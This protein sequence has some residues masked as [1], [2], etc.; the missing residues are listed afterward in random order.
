MG[1]EDGQGDGYLLLH[2]K[3]E[4]APP[5]FPRMTPQM[6]RIHRS[7]ALT[8][9]R[10]SH[11]VWG[12]QGRVNATLQAPR[13]PVRGLSRENTE[14]QSRATFNFTAADRPPRPPPPPAIF[15]SLGPSGL[16]TPKALAGLLLPLSPE[17][18]ESRDKGFT[19]RFPL[20]ET[21]R[22]R[23]KSKRPQEMHTLA[24]KSNY[25]PKDSCNHFVSF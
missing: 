3:D 21:V 7:E 4:R 24:P 22:R 1:A 13:L 23:G 18:A 2:F 10:P 16:G 20:L 19:K 9:T 6:P 14:T 12:E 8:A 17:G 11:R 25:F 15:P 5:A